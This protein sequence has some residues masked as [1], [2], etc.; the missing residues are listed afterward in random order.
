MRD[1]GALHTAALRPGLG[2]RRY[3]LGGPAVEIAGVAAML[4]ELTGRRLPHRAAPD[5]VLQ[6]AGRLADRAQRLI[7]VRLPVSAEQVELPIN[8]PAG[9]VVDDT[10]TRHELAVER[11]DLRETLAD[12]VR[13]LTPCA[14]WPHGALSPP[15]RLAPSPADLPPTRS[16]SPARPQQP[17]QSGELTAGRPA[18]NLQQWRTRRVP[19]VVPGGPVEVQ[20][21]DGV[22]GTA[23]VSPRLST[24]RRRRSSTSSLASSGAGPFICA[25]SSRRRSTGQSVPVSTVSNFTW[26]L[27][28]SGFP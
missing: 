16:T 20:Q 8:L 10:G 9:F 13:W 5:W 11:R 2:A 7:P 26:G 15:V 27:G 4:G 23:G 28:N 24:C 18:T 14:G 12:T 1:V 25:T 21:V 19:Q 17:V 3:L 22:D 6:R